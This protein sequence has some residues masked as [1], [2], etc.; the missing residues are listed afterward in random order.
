MMFGKARSNDKLS[1]QI[2]LIHHE[3][4][5]LQTYLKHNLNSNDLWLISDSTLNLIMLSKG[6]QVITSATVNSQLTFGA[7]AQNAILTAINQQKIMH[8]VDTITDAQQQ[9]IVWLCIE[10][11][12]ANHQCNLSMVQIQLLDN[13]LP[14]RSN[15]LALSLNSEIKQLPNLGYLSHTEQQIA[16]FIR[17][18]YTQTDIARMLATSRSSIVRRLNNICNKVG[19]NTNSTI[20][21]RKFLRGGYV[22]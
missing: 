3:V 9:H 4:D 5:Y 7:A 15:K 2:N 10:P 17:A 19:L 13:S 18:G 8:I 20:I 6:L 1:T 16:E 11:L 14:Q 22:D 12:V 21:L